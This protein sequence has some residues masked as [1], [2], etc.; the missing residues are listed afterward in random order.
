M[1]D[2]HRQTLKDVSYRLRCDTKAE[3]A[4]AEYNF[5]VFVCRW[6]GN[7]IIQN[8][9]YPS[10]CLFYRNDKDLVRLPTPA[11]KFTF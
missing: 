1:E 11:D 3:W 10:L 6:H 4:A 7:K 2:F 8:Y 5:F 9:Y